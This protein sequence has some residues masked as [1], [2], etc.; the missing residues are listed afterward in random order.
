MGAKVDASKLRRS[1][2]ASGSVCQRSVSM[3]SVTPALRRYST[4]VSSGAIRPTWAPSSALM[5]D[6]VMR[7]FIDSALTALPAYRSEEHT[8]ELQSLMRISYAVFC[9]KKKKLK[10]NRQYKTIN[11]K[12]SIHRLVL[13]NTIITNTNTNNVFQQNTLQH[14]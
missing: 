14:H 8:S 2:T 1:T 12:L 11:T 9:L 5:L 6:K 10:H 13:H 3:S 7:S 4:V